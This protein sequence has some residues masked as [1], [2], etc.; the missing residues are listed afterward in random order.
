MAPRDVEFRTHSPSRQPASPYSRPSEQI[1]VLCLREAHVVHSTGKSSDASGAPIVQT[2]GSLGHVRRGQRRTGRSGTQKQP[3]FRHAIRSPRG[4]G[5]LRESAGV[6]ARTLA[7]YLRIPTRGQASPIGHSAHLGR[8][9]RQKLRPMSH[10]GPSS[11]AGKS[12]ASCRATSTAR[13]GGAPRSVKPARWKSR[14]TCTSG[15]TS[16]CFRT[17]FPPSSP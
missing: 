16:S 9:G 13:C 14:R 4:F 10:A 8:R 17:C 1:F 11:A 7:S 15:F 2:A 3:N 5:F 12:G 6:R